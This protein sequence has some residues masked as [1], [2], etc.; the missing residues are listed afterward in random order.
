MVILKQL[1]KKLPTIISTAN[2]SYYKPHV[3]PFTQPPTTRYGG[4][5]NVTALPGDGIGPEMIE[6]IQKIFKYAQVPV[7]FEILELNSSDP[8]DTPLEHA[9]LSMKRNGVCIKGNIETKFNDPTFKSRNVE[10]RRRMDLYANILHCIT[11]PSIPTRHKGI[12]VVLIRENTEGEYSGMEHETV[13]GVVESLKI[14]TQKNIERIA[15][16]TFEYA[17]INNR[18]KVTAIHKA[19]IQKLGDG[20]FL[21]ICKEMADKEYPNIEFEAMIVDNACMQMVSRPQQFDVCVMPNLY[22]NIISNIACGLVG[23]PGLVSG[24]NVGD[25]YALFE[26][27][28]RNT[29]TSLAGKNIANPTAFIRSGIDLLRYLSLDFHA[30]ML[31]EALYKALSIQ[32]IHTSDIGGKAKS[33]DLINAVIENIHRKLDYIKEE[34]EVEKQI[35]KN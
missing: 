26:T 4:R 20:L 5:A 13:N 32:Q 31:N 25:K 8:T 11:I 21:K 17:V 24:V 30:E 12:D 28:T 3:F 16:Y 9:I 14:V 2:V 6:H 18:K 33:T 35:I 1:T 29:G 22:G 23:G 15:R 34:K 7:D 10:L 27:G 19:N